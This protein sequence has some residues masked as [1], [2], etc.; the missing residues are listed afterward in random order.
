MNEKTEDRSRICILVSSSPQSENTRTL[1]KITEAAVAMG[2]QVQIFLMSD[3]V[4]H[5]LYQSFSTLVEKGVEVALCAYD[6]ME[7]GLD[8]KTGIYFG[9]YYDLATMVA[10][11]DGFLALT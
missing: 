10:K 2:H 6:A 9:S 11:A 1:F 4:Y 5:I 7:R 8:K 3:G